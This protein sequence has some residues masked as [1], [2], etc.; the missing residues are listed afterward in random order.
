MDNKP[1][2]EIAEALVSCFERGRSKYIPS[3]EFAEQGIRRSLSEGLDV[4]KERSLRTFQ[5]HL[6]PGRARIYHRI[7]MREIKHALAALIL[8]G[9]VES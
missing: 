5:N 6:T 3:L 2:R 8:S 4:F 1:F 9:Q 7:F